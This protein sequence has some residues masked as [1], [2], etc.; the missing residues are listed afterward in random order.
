MR[1]DGRSR[2]PRFAT[3]AGVRSE[4][5]TARTFAPVNPPWGTRG[6]ICQR[7]RAALYAGV[8]AMGQ[9]VLSTTAT[10]VL[11][12]ATFVLDAAAFVLDA[13]AFVLDLATFVLDAAT[14]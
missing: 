5:R 9:G 12:A 8:V 4:C 10:F 13:A 1:G 2:S 14:C 6:S 3:R 7:V 11:D